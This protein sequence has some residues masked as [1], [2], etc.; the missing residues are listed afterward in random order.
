MGYLS[1]KFLILKAFLFIHGKICLLANKNIFSKDKVA[2][3][4]NLLCRT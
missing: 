4:F 2:I 3:T 1:S